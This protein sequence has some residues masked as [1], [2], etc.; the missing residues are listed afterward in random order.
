M[1]PGEAASLQEAPPP[2]P[3]PKSGWGLSRMVFPAWFP[4]RVGAVS[5]SLVESTA[6]DRAAADVR[7]EEQGRRFYVVLEM[8]NFRLRGFAVGNS[9][10]LGIDF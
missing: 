4:L 1:T 8:K 6:A 9:A 2:G 7:G 3:L 5:F 10:L